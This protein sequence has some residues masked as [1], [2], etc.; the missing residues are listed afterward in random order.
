MD[1]NAR[2]RWT[3][4]ASSSFSVMANATIAASMPHMAE[5]FSDTPNAPFLAK[6]ILTTPAL[7]IVIFAPLGGLFID[8]FGRVKFLFANMLLY[9]FAGASGFFLSDLHHILVGRALLGVA[10]AGI[11]TTTTTLIGDYFAG[12]ER[13]KYVGLQGVYFSFAGVL[14]VGAG[15]ILAE[16]DWRW[17]F[18]VYLSSWIVLIPAIKFLHEPSHEARNQGGGG[19]SPVPTQPLILAYALTFFLLVVFY[20]TPVQIPFLLRDMGVHSSGLAALAIC[21]GSLTSGGGAMM[22][23][24]FH[25]RVGFVSI[26]AYSMILVAVGY[27]LI[28][29]THSYAMV[30]VG[31]AISGFGAGVLFPN[32]AM[33]VTTLA[34]P[35]LR[36]RLL[37]MMTASMYLGQF[38]SPILVE[39][40]VAAVGLSG[41]FAL[42]ALGAIGMSI[43]L[44]ATCR[45]FDRHVG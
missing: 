5:V 39:P 3:L 28:A 26:Y 20:M 37:G 6:L 38:F 2:L 42:A 33:W 23:R 13:L 19:A 27:G 43:F 44:W 30:L 40:A 45:K 36:G 31:T 25:Y 35:R 9:G 12:A 29:T 32:A 4:L 10:V 18:L 41:A 17:P 14:F 22:Q 1:T 21:L 16:F 7:F 24:R 11:M 15:G 8:R 34:P